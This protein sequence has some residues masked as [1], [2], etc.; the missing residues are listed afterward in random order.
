MVPSMTPVIDAARASLAEAVRRGVTME[1]L[2]VAR[3]K[4]LSPDHC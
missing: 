1:D 3:K 2:M 4:Y